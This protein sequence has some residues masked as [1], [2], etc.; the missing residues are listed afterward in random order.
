MMYPC[1]IETV[2]S[3]CMEMQVDFLGLLAPKW[4]ILLK[5]TVV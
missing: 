1:S 4:S 3:T 5:N 2:D